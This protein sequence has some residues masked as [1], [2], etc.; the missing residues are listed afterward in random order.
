MAYNA[1]QH[2]FYIS[3]TQ[4]GYVNTSGFN[5]GSD[6]REKINIKNINTDK[7]LQRILACRPTTFQRVMDRTDP[8][9]SDEVK[10]RWHIGLI[11]QEV[12]SI[13]PHCIS[14][15]T[16]QDGETR[17]GIN[18]TDFVT[19]LIGSVQ[20]IVKQLTLQTT[21]VQELSKQITSHTETIQS[22]EITITTL[23]SS[24]ARLMVWAQAQGFS[25]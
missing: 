13:N 24:H 19:H 3:G 11:A 8:M 2:T 12:L 22:Q 1:V 21:L 7:S 9:I 17:Y 16:N 4:A 18:Y 10:N 6:E 14:E 5:N 25:G 23:L 15:W 20:E